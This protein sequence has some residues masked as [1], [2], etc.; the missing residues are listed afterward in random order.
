[1]EYDWGERGNFV[2]LLVS[3]SAHTAD[4]A[5]DIYSARAE[6]RLVPLSWGS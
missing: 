1:M 5:A 3:M 6:G 2:N 4:H